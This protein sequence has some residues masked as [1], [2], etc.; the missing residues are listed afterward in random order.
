ML[1]SVEAPVAV[2]LVHR[3]AEESGLGR[4][5]EGLE[6]IMKDTT[7]MMVDDAT[8][9]LKVLQAFLEDA[10][11][12]HFLP[13]NQPAEAFQTLIN[14]MPN[15]VLLD[16]N[17]PGVSGFDILAFMR[18]RE[19][20]Q[21]TP[22]IVLTSSSDAETKLRALQ[23]GAT[24]FLAKPVDE[25]EL[26]L[27]LRN[28]LV[29]KRY[30]D[31][32]TYYDRV[33]GLA[34]RRLFLDRLGRIVNSSARNSRKSAV[35][36]IDV[37]RFKKINDSLGHSVGD[38]LLQAI[39]GRLEGLVRSNDLVCRTDA[40]SL[41][42]CLAR[43]GGDVFTVLLSDV[44][45]IEV[46]SRVAERTLRELAKSFTIQGQELFIT[47]SIGVALFPE[48]GQ[49]KEIL[50]RHA[51]IAMSHAKRQGRNCHRVYCK[52]LDRK[53][54]HLL[55]L[56]GELHKAL[57][58][59][60]FVLHYQ[61]KV[62]VRTGLV[63]G[64]ETLVR[65]EHPER[66]MV[67]PGEFIALAEDTGLIGAIGGWVLSEACR[68]NAAWYSA[69]LRGLHLAV[70]VSGYQL[71]AL[72]FAHQVRDTLDKAGVEPHCLTLELTEGVMVE[73]AKENIELLHALKDIG[74]KLSV[75]DFG[76]G[77]SSLSYLEQFPLDELKVDRSFVSKIESVTG[78]API[79]SAII[80][81]A[82]SLRFKVV[83]EGVETEQQLAFLR[84]HECEQYQGYLFSKPLPADEFAELV[85]GS[86]PGRT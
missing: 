85:A 80:A 69:G 48:H 49:D 65:W 4:G 84:K 59:E 15:V 79:V 21:H 70:N 72:N 25:S 34:N 33:T 3:P 45:G 16:I 11:Y 62:D 8:T 37:D 53:N 7:I 2:S 82:R 41:H 39:A 63:T 28:T 81:M 68:Q 9:T 43:I 14:E 76:T 38:E 42:G 35:L 12:R 77:Y 46:A 1:D 22:V 13:V 5:N 20:F 67:P 44:D 29:A 51:D 73:D 26:V 47:A 71:R 36:L 61:P 86:R 52:D 19:E 60:E 64:A 83:A 78:G 54:R 17:M 31:Q 74:V 24:D 27:R 50:L 75:D 32:Q 57:E 23:L 10:G 6:D 55:T 58:R 66:G 40:A 56:E 30:L 18:A